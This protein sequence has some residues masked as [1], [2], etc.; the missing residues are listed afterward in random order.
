MKCDVAA[1]AHVSGVRAAAEAV[2]SWGASLGRSGADL[3]V[4][5][6]GESSQRSRHAS[7][8]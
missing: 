6:A 1:R 5:A 8:C 7:P 2:A 4:A 3:R